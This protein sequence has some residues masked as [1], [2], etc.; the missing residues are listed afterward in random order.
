MRHAVLSRRGRS[1]TSTGIAWCRSFDADWKTRAIALLFGW[2]AKYRVGLRPD[3][4]DHPLPTPRTLW[5][6][7]SKGTLSAMWWLGVVGV[8]VTFIQLVWGST[9]RLGS[10]T[11]AGAAIAFCSSLGIAVTTWQERRRRR[12]PP[13]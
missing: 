8:P 2:S 9:K 7:A 10:I 11:R 3:A 12:T 13:P 4:E 6:S 1:A 5:R